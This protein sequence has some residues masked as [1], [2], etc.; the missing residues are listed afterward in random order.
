MADG[1]PPPRGPRGPP[2]WGAG[3][4]GRRP[5]VAR[6]AHP[7]APG[8]PGVGV[9]PASARPACAMAAVPRREPSGARG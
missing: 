1:R 3:P 8:A 9:L 5:G 6:R 4:P 2:C 7:A